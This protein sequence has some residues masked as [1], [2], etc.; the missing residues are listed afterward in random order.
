MPRR[1]NL[2]RPMRLEINLPETLHTRLTLELFSELEGKIPKGKWSTFFT[3]RAQEY[4]A[5]RRLSLDPFG[6]PPGYFIA[7]PKEMI[8]ALERR[9]KA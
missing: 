3:E 6:F 9:L 5:W 7:G 4:F 8:D 1:P 2:D